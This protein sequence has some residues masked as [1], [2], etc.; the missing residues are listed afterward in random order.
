MRIN[1]MRISTKLV[2][3]FSIV[4]LILLLVIF[5][6]IYSIVKL[7]G[8]QKQV[9]H[10]YDNSVHIRDISNNLTNVYTIFSDLVVN[11]NFYDWDKNIS[12]V[13]NN[14]NADVE[15]LQGMAFSEED[16]QKVASFSDSYGQM[17]MLLEAG[18]DI[19]KTSDT[20]VSGDIIIYDSGIDSQRET[21]QAYLATIIEGYNKEASDADSDFM[22][23][24][25]LSLIIAVAVT[26]F[27]LIICGVLITLIYRYIVSNIN[28][29]VN[30]TKK[31]AE[32][33]FTERLTV[34]SS[35][36]FG[37]LAGSLNKTAENLESMMRNIQSAM[38]VLIQAINEIAVGN[39][40]LSQRTAEQASSVEEIAATI[41]ESSAAYRQNYDNAQNTSNIASRSASLAQSGGVLVDEAIVM[42]D[43]V[44][45]SSN[46]ISEI[47]DMINGI[48][49]QT[50]LLALNA[51]VEAARAG[52][53]GRGFAVVAGEVRNLAQRSA[54]AAKEIGNLIQE[55]VDNATAGSVKVNSSGTALKEII[56]SSISVNRMVAEIT[57]GM[58]EQKAGLDQINSAITDLDSMTQQNAALVEEIAS[59]SEE[60]QAQAKDLEAMISMFRIRQ[61]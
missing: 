18:H 15:F 2:L 35:D 31:L 16:L 60:M 55:S 1:D 11:R 8:L 40:N 6:Q 49:F 5:F 39:Q 52:E 42:M 21:S 46:K 28:N 19:L 27:A 33:D 50:N 38:I 12:T 58:N 4:V 22:K 3:S 59:S 25:R 53:Q 29:D 14:F 48:A 24:S 7:S 47:I 61:V 57:T 32:G 36:E 37:I 17:I 51:A 13:K 45:S 10:I 44:S 54:S 41:E 9:T 43:H 23:Q 34:S 56:E 26:F 30:Y 20:G